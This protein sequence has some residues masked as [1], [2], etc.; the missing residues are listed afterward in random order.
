MKKEKWIWMPHAG[1]FIGSKHCRFHLNTYV[2]KYIVSTVGELWWE[3]P[4]REIHA[5]IYDKV[6][7]KK[8]K[9]LKGDNFDHAY[10]ERF[11]FEEIG[12]GR[13]YETMVFKSIKDKHKCCPY[14]ASDWSEIDFNGYKTADEATI[15]HKKMCLKWSKK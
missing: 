15:G 3:R 13:L 2:G 14:T 7:Y 9:D 10:M 8:N 11:G 6:W 1:H 12:C 4:S 5:K